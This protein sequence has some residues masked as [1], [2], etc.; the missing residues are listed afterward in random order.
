[1][2]HLPVHSFL[3][4]VLLL[5]LPLVLS[6]PPSPTALII[7]D[8][9]QCFS[10]SGSLPVRGF[11]SILPVINRLRSLPLFSHVFLTQDWHP[12]HHIGFVTSHS[13]K[14]P[15]D[16]ILLSYDSHGRLCG[17]PELGSL[18]VPCASSASVSAA[19]AYRHV[20]QTLWPVHCVMNT[21]S[22]AFHPELQISASDV[23]IRKGASPHVD[24]YSALYDVLS[25]SPTALPAALSALA[26]RTVY[27][28][29]V[30]LDVC[31]LFTALDARRL[32]Y[33]VVVVRDATGSIGD[34]EE[35]LRRMRAAG[36]TVVD[37]WQ[38]DGYLE[39]ADALTIGGAAAAGGRAA[40]PQVKL[41]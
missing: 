33:N 31:V 5:L 39:A 10:S 7:V 38:V 30:A 29:G 24:S 40:F 36:V 3:V 1:M 41:R 12:A 27:I 25:S 14:Q 37:S 34:G 18:S 6:S 15:F 22:S 26:V 13:G 17:R 23:V 2:L 4:L 35:E 20:N 28:V 8:I 9:Q 21:P 11:E 19:A 16:S 32:G